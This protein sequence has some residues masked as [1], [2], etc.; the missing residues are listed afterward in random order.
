MLKWIWRGIVI[1]FLGYVGF[2]TY[3]L[4]RSGYFSLPD[5]ADDE[6]PIS[7][8]NGFRAIV[9]MPEDLRRPERPLAPKLFRRLAW[10]Y[11]ERRYLG[12]PVDVPSW[13][14]HAWSKCIAGDEAENAKVQAQI[15]AAMPEK[16]RN[17]LF[18]ARLDAV[19]GV[20]VD[21]NYVLRGYIYSVPRL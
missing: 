18:G 5:L 8:R 11:S 17:D 12:I 1:A 4:Q 7:F 19:C 16:L 20:E 2:A 10:E 6:Y 3:D 15:E 14:K 9:S 21:G 13:L